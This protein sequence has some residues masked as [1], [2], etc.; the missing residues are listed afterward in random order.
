MK[1][2]EDMK[3]LDELAERLQMNVYSDSDIRLLALNLKS[4]CDGVDA[5]E[6]FGI[7]SE[8]KGM[9]RSDYRPHRKI[10]DAFKRITALI[11]PM[12]VVYQEDGDIRVVEDTTKQDRKLIA[13]F[14]AVAIQCGFKAETLKTYWNSGKYDH[15]KTAEA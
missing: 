3:M 6:V 13:A 7:N 1:L 5:H 12:K 4:I 2:Y 9:R 14:R 10:A 8:E 15:L 11:D